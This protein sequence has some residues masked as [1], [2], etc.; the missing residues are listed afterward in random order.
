M[1][2]KGYS[3]ISD[4]YPLNLVASFS[5]SQEQWRLWAL[6]TIPKMSDRRAAQYK[7]TDQE[8]KFKNLIQFIL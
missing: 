7:I 4:F 1:F 6:A 8:E 2:Y 3:S 5:N